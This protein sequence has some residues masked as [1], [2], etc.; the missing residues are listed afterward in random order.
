MNGDEALRAL[1]RAIVQNDL[2]IPLTP[3]ELLFIVRAALASKDAGPSADQLFP[4][5]S[6]EGAGSAGG[7]AYDYSDLTRHT[8]VANTELSRLRAWEKWGR[9]HAKPAIKD[10]L[11]RIDRNGGIGEYKGGPAF[12]VKRA[13]EALAALPQDP[14]G[15]VR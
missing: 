13:R 5:P 3:N 11:D 10:L 1:E 9:E 15:G 8:V 7:L 6:Q 12:A 14:Q 4:V 2:A